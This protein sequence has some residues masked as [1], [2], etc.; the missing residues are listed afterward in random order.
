ML[1]YFFVTSTKIAIFF[2]RKFA[3]ALQLLV[4]RPEAESVSE[5]L[6]PQSCRRANK[7]IRDRLPVTAANLFPR[8]SFRIELNLRDRPGNERGALSGINVVR[9]M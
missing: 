2:G 6:A 7:T 4:R 8:C 9:D 1:R 5:G 3:A